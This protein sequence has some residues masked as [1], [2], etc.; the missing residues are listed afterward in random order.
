MR[1]ED[2]SKE[3]LSWLDP[4]RAPRIEREFFVTERDV[5]EVNPAAGMYDWFAPDEIGSLDAPFPDAGSQ[6]LLVVVVASS[7]GMDIYHMAGQHA[8]QFP[9]SSNRDLEWP[10]GTCFPVPST[11][12]QRLLA[13]FDAASG[14]LVGA[15]PVSDP[16]QDRELSQLAK[17]GQSQ[18][19]GATP[20]PRSSPTAVS[21]RASTGS[22]TQP[23][24]P[25]LPRDASAPKPLARGEVPAALLDL[26]REYPL[27]HGAQWVYR[28]ADH[29][30]NVRSSHGVI[31]NTIDAAW[32][33]APDVMIVR[34]QR[35]G[36][37]GIERRWYN[38][39]SRFWFVFPEGIV[40]DLQ[41][42]TLDAAREALREPASPTS[43]ASP[44]PEISI[45][46]A[47]P[48]PPRLT[49]R[50]DYGREIQREEAMNAPAGT[51]P[52]CH[53]I[54]DIL[55]AGNSSASWLC[56]G[57]GYVRHEYPGCSTMYGS[58]MTLELIRYTLPYFTTPR[59]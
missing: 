21:P 18:L 49:E 29:S 33:I 20:L 28:R 22:A 1:L 58:H 48:I 46:E 9:S 10:G 55:N 43:T 14:S 53:L 8:G 4:R 6:R 27:V 3:V 50:V 15:G 38:R 41:G 37:A 13:I 19:V 17:S 32:Q 44:R 26:V 54:R 2:A 5:M 47:L 30:N 35:V 7:Q 45:R 16:D 56:R 36:S 11:R 24:L 40:G 25:D 12:R 31:T 34:E 57:V 42:A 51:F 39:P 52:S 59:E 23:P